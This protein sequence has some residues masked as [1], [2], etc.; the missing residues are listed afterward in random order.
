ML[1]EAYAATESGRIG[2]QTKPLAHAYDLAMRDADLETVIQF[3]Q[4]KARRTRPF[5]TPEQSVTRKW[6]NSDSTML[7]AD[8]NGTRP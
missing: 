5:T 8:E 3:M 1:I 6:M 7:F 4:A 2:E